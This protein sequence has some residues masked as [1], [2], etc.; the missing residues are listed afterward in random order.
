[1]LL[2][3]GFFMACPVVAAPNAGAAAA[4]PRSK[5]PRREPRQQVV[6]VD[7]KVTALNTTDTGAGGDSRGVWKPAIPRIAR[8]GLV[9]QEAGAPSFGG[10]GL[11]PCDSWEV[12]KCSS[13]WDEA[14]TTCDELTCQYADSKPA[15]CLPWDWS[16]CGNHAECDEWG[17]GFSWEHCEWANFGYPTSAASSVGASVLDSFANASSAARLE[18]NASSEAQ[19]SW[20]GR[21]RRSKPTIGLYDGVYPG[22]G[23]FVDVPPFNPSTNTGGLV[24]MTDKD[25]TIE[26][27][28]GGVAGV[29]QICAGTSSK[30]EYPGVA[31]F[32]LALARGTTDRVTGVRKPIAF[33]ARP[34]L[35]G[36]APEV[37]YP[38]FA[39][40]GLAHGVASWG[41]EPI[42]QSGD[43]VDFGDAIVQK[44]GSMETDL[45][46][47]DGMAY[48]KYWNWK[49]NGATAVR[50][51]AV[52]VGDNGQG[53]AVAAQM[54]LKRSQGISD[55]AGAVKAAF[56]HDI[57]N[58]GSPVCVNS[59]AQPHRGPPD[60]V[61]QWARRG[62]FVFDTYLNAA[63]TALKMGLIS[64]AGCQSVCN[65]AMGA[66][67]AVCPCR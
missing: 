67:G 26:C 10:P 19:W 49:T 54:M 16:C 35:F 39:E 3:I 11:G 34:D 58:G 55:S 12:C 15:T 45:T 27:S 23:M 66:L 43:I 65:A 18:G 32:Y 31:E 28:G 5:L 52:F 14:A 36:W 38:H 48:T 53:D 50:A 22:E 63:S 8:G 46:R 62:I 56:I 51:A 29:D 25:D 44:V 64:P 6:Q 1:M 47:F 37:D 41:I 20:E 24:V 42:A 59:A 57:K 40:V 33:S 2:L 30:N 7:G 60:C 13:T 21:R 4:G 9:R 17:V 61:D